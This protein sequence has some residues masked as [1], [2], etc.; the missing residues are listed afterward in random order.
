MKQISRLLAA[1]YLTQNDAKTAI[2]FFRRPASFRLAPSAVSFLHAVI[3]QERS[4]EELEME[5]DLPARSA[6]GLLRFLLRMAEETN[7]Q[8]SWLGDEEDGEFVDPDQL[9]SEEIVAAQ[10]RFR[11]TRREAMVLN[12]LL[13]GIGRPVSHALIIERAC[14][15][16]LID[17]VKQIAVYVHRL[18]KKLRPYGYRITNIFGGGYQIDH[19]E[20]VR[21]RA[22]RNAEWVRRHH[23]GEGIRQI[24]RDAMVQPSTVMRV[25]RGLSG[26]SAKLEEPS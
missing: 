21:V 6:K 22:E 14:L 7:G 12:A 13:A 18:R 4:L 2:A 8:A 10:Q 5:R 9:A 3:V 23:E 24:A 16:D 15:E 26:S 1:G 25:V 20:E 11:I 19:V 17:P